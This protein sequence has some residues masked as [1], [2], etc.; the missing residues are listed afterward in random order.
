[1]H[2]RAI[3]ADEVGLG[4]TIEAGLI[5]TELI[6]RKLVSRV[7]ILVPSSLVEQWKEELE[8]KFK[9]SC[10]THEQAGFWRREVVLLSL[11]RAKGPGMASRL[12]RGR[13]DIVVVDE[14]HALKNAR[15]QAHA[16]VKTLNPDRLL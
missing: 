2:C 3:L 7:L 16:F 13:W 1:M 5:L 12:Q 4:K 15:T 6:C 8:A 10:A 14:A 11:T 9:L